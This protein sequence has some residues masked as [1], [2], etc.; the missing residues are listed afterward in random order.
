MIVKNSEDMIARCLEGCK[1][2]CD[3]L[4]VVDTGSVDKTVE[5]AKTFTN[6]VFHFEWIDD[7]SAARNFALNKCTGDY[8]MMMDGD[9]YVIPEMKK[10]FKSFVKNELSK[11]DVVMLGWDI[12]KKL[13]YKYISKNL[14]DKYLYK[15]PVHEQFQFSSDDKYT[16]LDDVF[17][18]HAPLPSTVTS[19]VFPPRNVTIMLKNIVREEYLSDPYF[20]T[21]TAIELRQIPGTEPLQKAL[22]EMVMKKPEGIMHHIQIWG[23]ANFLLSTLHQKV[24]KKMSSAY[25]QEAYIL[26]PNSI[27]I[28]NV[29][30]R[31]YFDN[32]LHDHVI[33]LLQS[34]LAANTRYLADI[35]DNNGS[36]LEA[37]DLL[38]YCLFMKKRYGDLQKYMEMYEEIWKANNGDKEYIPSVNFVIYSQYYVVDSYVQKVMK[39]ESHTDIKRLA[40]QYYEYNHD[41]SLFYNSIPFDHLILIFRL[42]MKLKPET[43][44]VLDSEIV[45]YLIHYYQENYCSSLSWNYFNKSLSYQQSEENLYKLTGKHLKPLAIEDVESYSDSDFAI[46]DAGQFTSNSIIELLETLRK[47]NSKMTICMHSVKSADIESILIKDFRASKLMEKRSREKIVKFEDPWKREIYIISLQRTRRKTTPGIIKGTRGNTRLKQ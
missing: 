37:I 38:T 16:H 27:R 10:R 33:L 4:I 42:L 1:D 2:I 24:D 19:V 14:K 25:L 7:F 29:L 23:E 40:H 43:V 5:I 8:R 9:D 31:T 36:K 47:R 3:E 30:A 6:N 35:Y 11:Y 28:S 18:V 17:F 34:A 46:I 22:L 39:K 20:L 41:T 45:C 15:Y 13:S 26:K 44:L 21:I 12:G 32:G